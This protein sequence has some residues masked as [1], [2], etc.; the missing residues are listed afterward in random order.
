MVAHIARAH[1]GTVEVESEEG[2]GST[3]RLILPASV[4]SSDAA[5]HYELA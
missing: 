1:D 2:K 5:P 3:F 4:A